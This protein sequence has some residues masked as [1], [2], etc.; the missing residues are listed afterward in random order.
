MTEARRALAVT[1]PPME[2]RREVLVNTA[3]RAEEL[4]YDGFFVTEAWGLDALCLLAEI[5]TKTQRITL[6][7]GVLGV[8]SRSSATLAMAAATLSQI[9]GSRFILGLGASTPQLVEG[10]HDVA[11]TSPVDQ[12]R[13]VVTQTRELLAGNRVPLSH[14]TEARPLRLAVPPEPVPIYLAGLAPASVRLSGEIADGWMPTLLPV[15]RTADV[16]TGFRE[17]TA[18]RRPQA[19][20][21]RFCPAI[22]TAVSTDETVARQRAA[23]WVAFYLTSMGRIYARTVERLG[24]SAEVKTVQ[25]ANPNS[26]TSTVPREA[27]ALLDELVVFGT[28]DVAR[29]RLARWYELGAELPIVSIPPNLPPEEVEESLRALAP[30]PAPH[31]EPEAAG[32]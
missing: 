7:T 18:T 4:G 13:R 24:F 12:L 28:P 17:A 26:S 15:S 20:P 29:A 23:W 6:G 9:S 3:V 32:T 2:T 22:P 10:L 8:W 27:D 19:Q 21:C 1:F 16:L 11:F 25:A 14:T 30:R 5:A 31:A